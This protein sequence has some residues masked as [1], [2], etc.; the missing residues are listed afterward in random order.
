MRKSSKA[1]SLVL[2]GLMATSCFS[3]VA[4]SAAQVETESTGAVLTAK[5]RLDAGHQLVFFQFPSSAWGDNANVKYNAKK[6]T[7]N[8]FCNYYAVYGNKG[9]VKESA[10]EA[11]STSMYKDAKGD[12]LY[13]FDITEG[14]KGELEEGA[15]YGVLFSTKA[16]AGQTDLL[17]PNTDG[18]QT[19]DMYFDTT[20]LGTTY[21]IV[22]PASKETVRE[23]TANSQKIDYLGTNDTVGKS[24]RKVSTLCA[25]IDGAKA[26]NSPDSLEMANALQTYL[27][28]PVNEPSFIWKN[29]EPVLA[30]F[31]TT[32]QAVY[33]MYV[34]KYGAKHD[35]GT[36]Y[37]PV[38]DGSDTKADGTL[39]DCYRYTSI[40]TKELDEATGVEKEKITK[41]PDFDLVRERLNLPAEPAVVDIESV[42]ATMDGEVKATQALP[43]VAGAVGANYSSEA[44]WAP[45]DETAA[46]ST[47]YT[48]TVTFTADEGYQFTD[49][50][51]A[52]LNDKA[53]DSVTLTDGKLVATATFKTEDEPA[54]ESTYIVAGSE[55]EIFGTAW[56][57]GNEDNLMAKAEDG[58]FTKDYT[59]TK[60]YSAVQLKTVKDGVE[61]IGDKTGNNVTFDLTGEGT[62]TVVYDPEE[63]YTYVKGDIVK[64]IT[65]CKCDAV[66]AVGNGEGFWLN[67]VAWDPAA[68][69]NKMNKVA[70]DV[71]EIEFTEV[72]DGFE[73]QIKFAI[74]GAWTHNFGGAFE[75]SGV[76]TAAAYNGDNITFDTD[77]TCTVKAQ[78]DLREFDFATKEGAKFTITIEY[79]PAE[80]VGIIG[81][82][83]GDGQVTIDDATQIQQRGIELVKFDETQEK[84]ADVNRDGRISILDVTCVQKY[85]ALYTEGK[86]NA[87]DKLL[88]D[89]RIIP[90]NK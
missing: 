61:W 32:A 60:A 31:G 76:A 28:N 65:E 75:E 84:L 34:E 80:E 19:C 17:Q 24:V 1:I 5:Q 86:G 83:T 13:Y 74:D 46:Y 79:A 14:G 58:T 16:N 21:H 41:Y 56:D 69:V 72:P 57:G 77:D 68:E 48:L 3:M 10:W 54:G 78:L 22:E 18:F 64:E 6:K 88:A 59:V 12:S 40:T 82:V 11:P 89:G 2:S 42:S 36:H 4:A 43:A 44:V 29:I 85:L 66:F 71:W 50:T 25:Y 81:D 53:F 9:E 23:N 52:A 35:E 38:G 73:R 37:V 8:V 55:A 67:G 90:A 49:A 87:G 26:G 39:K 51:T 15:D 47:E 62:F 27:P 30:K 70:D 20:C 63:N 33:D 45:A 7:C